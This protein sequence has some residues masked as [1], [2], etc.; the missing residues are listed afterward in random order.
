[1]HL[2]CHISPASLPLFFFAFYLP[3]SPCRDPC[4]RPATIPSFLSLPLPTSAS[5]EETTSGQHLAMPLLF[6][7]VNSPSLRI[8]FLFVCL[9]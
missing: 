9:H 1:M 4:P 7:D 6:T 8:S 3:H 5:A 2:L